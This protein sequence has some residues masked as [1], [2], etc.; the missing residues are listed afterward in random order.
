MKRDL[1]IEDKILL[2][3]LRDIREIH[4]LKQKD[5]AQLLNVTRPNYTRWETKAN[6]IPLKK[7]NALCNFFK[8]DM[9]YI[10]GINRYPK[11]MQNNNIIDKELIGKNIKIF[12]H[13]HHLTQEEL[14]KILHT[15]HSVISSYE[16]GKTLILTAFLVQIAI[17]YNESMDLIC[18]RK[19]Q[20]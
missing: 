3:N 1:I 13:K 5:L 8:V 2:D 16:H 17:K 15:T 18:G 6:M 20:K 10:M 4:N 9:D 14:A 12:R 7:L 11:K 19:E